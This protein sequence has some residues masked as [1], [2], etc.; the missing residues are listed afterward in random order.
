MPSPEGLLLLAER[1]YDARPR[2]YL[3]TIGAASFAL[4]E[5]LSPSVAAALPEAAALVRRVL[6]TPD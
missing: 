2:A 5:D 6:A 1:L 4:G 3:V